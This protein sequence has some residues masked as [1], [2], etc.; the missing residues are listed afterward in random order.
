MTVCL[1]TFQGEKYSEFQK[2][3]NSKSEH[4]YTTITLTPDSL[5]FLNSSMSFNQIAFSLFQGMFL[6]CYI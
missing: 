2:Q 4:Q 6:K 3:T 1:R 5:K